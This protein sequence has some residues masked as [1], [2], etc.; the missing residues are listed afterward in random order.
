MSA[1][2]PRPRNPWPPK[3]LFRWIDHLTLSEHLL[4]LLMA[5]YAGANVFRPE[6]GMLVAAYPFPACCSA[7]S[8][9]LALLLWQV[10]APSRVND[11]GL[12]AWFTNRRE[13][14]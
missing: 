4:W 14:Q 6:S 9:G 13:A 1:S 2:W 3:G 7:M 10:F 12:Q 11:N 8:A 5:A